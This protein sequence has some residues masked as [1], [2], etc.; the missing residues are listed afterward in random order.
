MCQCV[1]PPPEIKLSTYEYLCKVLQ[2]I[3]RRFDQP[4]V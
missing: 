2:I 3:R 1:A 4:S